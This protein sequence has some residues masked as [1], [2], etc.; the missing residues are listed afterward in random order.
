MIV[1][2]GGRIVV[3]AQADG[4]LRWRRLQDG[5]EFLAAF[6]A[7]DGHHWVA[8]TAHGYYAASPGGEALI[9]WQLDHGMERTPEFFPVWQF[10]DRFHRPD[11]VR[12]VLDTLDEG[13]ALRTADQHGNKETVPAAVTDHLPPTIQIIEPQD[14]RSNASEPHV[15]LTYMV[16]S[17]STP[18]DAIKIE[19]QIEGS[20]GARFESARKPGRRKSGSRED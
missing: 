13:A 5:A 10:R 17:P 9:G 4:T 20:P 19:A 12:A 3:S 6:I 2:P 1:P 7:P 11:V 8:W 14:G 18:L 16:T 15:S